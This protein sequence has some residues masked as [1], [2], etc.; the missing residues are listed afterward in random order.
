MFLLGLLLAGA[1]GCVD[2]MVTV[3]IRHDG[4]GEVEAAFAIPFVFVD[5]YGGKFVQL[6]TNDLLPRSREEAQR[7]WGDKRGVE[8]I[9]YSFEDRKTEPPKVGLRLPDAMSGVRLVHMTL[10]FD[11]V[12]SLNS[13]HFR[14][15]WFPWGD[16]HYF[17]FKIAKTLDAKEVNA[18]YGGM[19]LMTAALARD[20]KIRLVAD[21]P[22]RIMT[23]NGQSDK[24]K[25][26]AWDIPLG[27]VYNLVQEEVI[28]WAKLPAQPGHELGKLWR[29]W[30]E[31]FD[32]HP[33][34]DPEKFPAYFV[35]P[36]EEPSRRAATP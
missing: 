7:I 15:A 18:P 23:T 36:V 34:G 14:F 16:D 19:G 11:E 1:T 13:R 6:D 9:S 26:V 3:T 5:E 21:L 24:W 20:R 32:R 30:D 27:A 2:I 10:H 12:R 25:A 31:L 4:S 35:L 33:F 8:L 22:A 29:S 17:A 28:G